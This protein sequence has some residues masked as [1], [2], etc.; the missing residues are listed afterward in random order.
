MIIHVVFLW[1]PVPIVPIIPTKD[2]GNW[3]RGKGEGTGSQSWL[4]STTCQQIGDILPIQYFLTEIHA[5]FS[6]LPIRSFLPSLLAK[7]CQKYGVGTFPFV[8]FK[9]WLFL[10][11]LLNFCTTCYMYLVSLMPTYQK[12]LLKYCHRYKACCFFFW[13]DPRPLL[14]IVRILEYLSLLHLPPPPPI[15]SIGQN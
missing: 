5:F 14:S 4:L 1:Y 6:S 8:T 12:S 2:S 3:T 9:W 7:W 15:L 11:P 13:G 10:K